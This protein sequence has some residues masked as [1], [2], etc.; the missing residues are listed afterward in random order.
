M[1][2]RDRDFE[3]KM[4]ECNVKVSVNIPT[5]NEEKALPFALDAVMKQTYSNIETIVIDSYSRDKTPEIALDYG[6]QVIDYNGK[7]LGARYIGAEE[8]K[9]EY[10]LL[11][12]ADQIL[13]PDAIERALVKIKNLDMLIFEEKA[14]EEKTYIQKILSKE[15]ADAHKNADALD[16]ISGA[17]LPRFYKKDILISTFNNIPKELYHTVVA[18]DHA[19]IYY[20]ARKLSS[21]IGILDNYPV[22]HIDPESLT[23]VI[24]HN[25]RFGRSTKALSRS[26]HYKEL[27][28]SK[29]LQPKNLLPSV[30]NK[31]FLVSLLRS[32]AY[33][34]GYIL[35]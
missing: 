30:K 5:F 27:F 22:S 10:I 26:G 35:G 17:L 9:G 29:A 6:A 7:L 33:Q 11:L 25:Y 4:V 15:R 20:E 2:V 3:V 8:S 13:K 28:S 34:I 23:E 24:L 18:H 1:G 14:F 21:R 32:S 12:D 31:R 16:P 19:I